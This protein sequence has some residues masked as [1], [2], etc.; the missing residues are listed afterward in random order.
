MYFIG[1]LLDWFAT[2]GTTAAWTADSH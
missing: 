2:F 1:I